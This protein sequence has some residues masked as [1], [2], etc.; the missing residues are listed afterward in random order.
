ML[1]GLTARLIARRPE[2]AIVVGVLGT[3]AA[4]VNNLSIPGPTWMWGGLLLFLPGAMAG[5]RMGRLRAN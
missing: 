5:D 3:A 1:G 4:I 2:P